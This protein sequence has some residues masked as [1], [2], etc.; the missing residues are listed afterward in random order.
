MGDGEWGVGSGERK[1][2]TPY[3]LLTEEFPV[4]AECREIKSSPIPYSLFPIPYSLFPTPY[5][6]LPTPHFFLHRFNE[7]S[8][9]LRPL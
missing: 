3:S 9:L 1:S 2:S 7:R 4:L 8:H 6:L 5:S